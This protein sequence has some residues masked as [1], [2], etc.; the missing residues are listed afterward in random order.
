MVLV[1]KIKNKVRYANNRILHS[2]GYCTPSN[3]VLHL[4]RRCNLRCPH[5]LWLLYDESFFSD[6]DMDL[7][8]AKHILAYFKNKYCVK[9]FT[10]SAEGEV[11]LY[12]GLKELIRFARD[13]GY[14]KINLTTNGILLDKYTDF[15]LDFL[16]TL[17][18]SIDGYNSETYIL[19]RGG[20]EATFKRVI[21]NARSLIEKKKKANK[22]LSVIM[23][24]IIG[25]FNLGYIEPMIRLAED[26]KADAMRFGAYH[27][28]G[29]D[30]DKLSPLYYG[31]KE[32]EGYY[33]N[34]MNNTDWKVD[35]TLPSLYGKRSKFQCSML[36]NAVQIG[37]K[38]NFAPCCHIPTND[39]YGNFFT[40]PD[41]FNS[42][43]LVSF[44]RSFLRGKRYEDLPEPCR[45]CP[46]LSPTRYKF[47]NKTKSWHGDFSKLNIIT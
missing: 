28:T 20:T 41:G 38:G 14:K 11:F 18:V 8:R 25:R 15:L 13:I 36:F 33:R 32:A 42:K 43:K 44:R 27:P 7:E 31:D 40:K 17:T 37:V 45:E 47:L 21:N 1:D 6:H 46:R 10:A 16:D 3:L 5:C 24:C 30:K 39:K 22:R 34:I 26:L 9:N 29:N 12:D 19:R 4:T 23:N 35:I 2:L